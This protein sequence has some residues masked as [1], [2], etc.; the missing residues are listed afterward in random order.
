MT[1]RGDPVRTIAVL[2]GGI[3]GLTA[4]FSL[5]RLLPVSKYRI[6]VV[7]ARPRLGGYIQSERVAVFDDA[8]GPET[9]L[10]EY[11]PRTVIPHGY[12]GYR[13]LELLEQLDL[14]D[15]MLVVPKTSASARNRFLYHDEKLERLASS[16]PAIPGV[17][18]RVPWMRRV[19]WRALREPWVEP[20]AAL[21]TPDGSGDE[22]VDE[23]CARRLGRDAADVLASAMMHGIY[24]G[25]SR[26]ISVRSAFPAL[27]ALEQKHGSLLGSLFRCGKRRGHAAVSDYMAA[28]AHRKRE[29]AAR[30]AEPTL[31]KIH[32]ASVYSFPN[33]LGE[34]T[35][36]L[37]RHLT[38][39][40]N[41]EVWT[42]SP[43]ERIDTPTDGGPFRAHIA[44]EREPLAAD[45]I[46]AA[47]PA[48]K[49]APFFP[50]MPHLAH[51]PA[52]HVGVV[53]VVLAPPDAGTPLYSLPVRGFGYLVPRV[54]RNN[55]DQ[56]LGVIFDSDAVSNQGTPGETTS[57]PFAKL[58]VMVGGPYW[59]ALGSSNLPDTDEITRRALRALGGQLGVPTD[60]LRTHV[61]YTRARI[62]TDCIPQYQVGH[63]WRMRELH[64]ALQS[65]PRW[66]DRLTLVGNS[67]TGVGVNDCVSMTLDATEAIALYEEG[68]VTHESTSQ[69]TGLASLIERLMR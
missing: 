10:L 8:R 13:M 59:E 58:T 19:F 51:N 24:A 27:V 52:A 53:D 9:A 14:V 39:A 64:D 56:I 25:D 50:D 37:Q 61:R 42:G 4:A 29:V 31:A 33:G 54:A 16:L 11:G 1:R 7:E 45:R 12:R 60:V 41:V 34:I 22:S 68:D 15:R 3:S 26:R 36:A 28:E 44:D 48:A 6:V 23:F 38:A 17:L 40:E 66:R 20:S 30:L 65:D 57:P 47:L 43:C 49:L 46:V 62:L 21:H 55:P 67:Y 63:V 2:G 18:W 5:R 69:S 35:A 32:D